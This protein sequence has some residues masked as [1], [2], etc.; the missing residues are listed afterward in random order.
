MGIVSKRPP[1][2]QGLPPSYTSTLNWQIGTIRLVVDAAGA[3]DLSG[4]GMPH[5]RWIAKAL[6]GHGAGVTW[7]APCRAHQDRRLSPRSGTR[8]KK[9]RSTGMPAANCV[10]SALRARGFWSDHRDIALAIWRT[11]RRVARRPRG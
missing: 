5:D 9:C 11:D 6:S 7:I 8:M 2:I 1:V 4:R 3:W 10:I